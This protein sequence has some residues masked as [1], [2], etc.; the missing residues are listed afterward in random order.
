VL[1]RDPRVGQAYAADPLRHGKMSAR[2]FNGLYSAGLWALE[3]AADFPLPL[4]L[5]HGDGDRL[6]SARASREFAARAPQ[7]TFKAWDGLY[8]ELHNEPEQQQIF[9]VIIGWLNEHTPAM[10]V[11]HPSL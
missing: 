3:H 10:A 1:S 8:H 5:M 9:A 7:C 4:L 11:T 2:M 6:T